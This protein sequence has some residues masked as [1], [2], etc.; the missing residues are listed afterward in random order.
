[1]YSVDTTAEKDSE[2]E[3]ENVSPVAHIYVILASAG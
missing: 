1:M 3:G 2:Y